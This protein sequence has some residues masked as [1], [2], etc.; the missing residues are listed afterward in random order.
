MKR[1][2]VTINFQHK[3]AVRAILVSLRVQYSMSVDIY[4][5]VVRVSVPRAKSVPFLAELRRFSI[6]YELI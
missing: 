2:V 4:T 3:Q 5:A 6:P 1:T